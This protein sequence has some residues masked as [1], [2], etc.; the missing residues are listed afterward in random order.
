MESR[1]LHFLELSGVGR[2]IE[3]GSNED[4]SRAVRLD[5]WVAWEDQA[6]EPD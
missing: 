5:G 4:E 3:D 2:R 1:L 6:R